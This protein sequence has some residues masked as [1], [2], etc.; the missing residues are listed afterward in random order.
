MAFD[1]KI[2]DDIIL[3]ISDVEEQIVKDSVPC[4][5]QW[6][7]AGVINIIL[8]KIDASMKRLDDEWVVKGK[9]ESNGVTAIPTNRD[10]RASLIFSQSNYKNRVERDAEL[11]K[12]N[13]TH[14]LGKN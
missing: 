13:K 4:Y 10:A 6:I 9:L 11:S 5:K 2:N 3:S 14:G 1:L 8:S 7:K 12:K